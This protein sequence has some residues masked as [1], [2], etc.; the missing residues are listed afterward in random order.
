MVALIIFALLSV[1]LL[2]RIGDNLRAQQ[3]L[4]SKN[5]AVLVAANTLA[6]LRIQKDWDNV[7]SKTETVT[8][9]GQ[10]WLVDA[11]VTDTPNKNLRRVDV[12]VG[13]RERN[14]S[15]NLPIFTLTSFIGHY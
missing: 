11:T 4:E 9:A 5:T 10:D 6:G 13:L 12:K 7:R 14:S 15:K 3:H 2:L 1:T 8:M